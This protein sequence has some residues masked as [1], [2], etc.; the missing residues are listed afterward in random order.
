MKGLGE[1]GGKK[2]SVRQ[3]NT[4]FEIRKG[5]KGRGDQHWK[6]NFLPCGTKKRKDRG[7][8]GRGEG[9]VSDLGV[10]FSQ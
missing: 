9:V 3:K 5:F 4:S 8:T 10:H 6:I 2:G 1:G 7:R